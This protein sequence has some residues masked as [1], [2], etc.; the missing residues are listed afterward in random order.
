MWFMS[1]ISKAAQTGTDEHGPT[2]TDT[3]RRREGPT[4]SNTTGQNGAR[5]NPGEQ[6]V[7]T[8]GF[9]PCKEDSKRVVIFSK[10]NA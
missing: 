9:P 7:G 6:G 4:G 3:D 8:D 1:W 10:D 2:R 5:R